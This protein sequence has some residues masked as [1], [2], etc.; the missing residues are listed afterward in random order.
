LIIIQ[1][2]PEENMQQV[3][4]LI[5]DDDPLVCEVLSEIAEMSGYETITAYDGHKALEI[6]KR[7]FPQ[8][9]MLDLN[10]PDINGMEVLRQTKSI[11]PEA[12]VIV[13]TGCASMDLLAE[14]LKFG[15][16]DFIP[17][18]F[19]PLSI[20]SSFDRASSMIP[21]VKKPK[22]FYETDSY[23]I[24][25]EDP[26]MLGILEQMKLIAQSNSNIMIQGESGTG[27]ELI[28]RY[29][30]SSSDRANG[31]FVA[32]N[33]AALPEGVLESELFGHEKGAFTGAISRRIGKI[34]LAH[35]G[36]L[37]LDEISEMPKHFQSK[38]LRAIQEREVVR[39]GGNEQ[40]K[41]DVRFIAT[42]N[43]NIMDEVNDGRFREDLFYR[44]CVI[45][46]FVPP[47]RNRKCD[48]SILAHHFVNKVAKKVGKR[49]P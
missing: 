4:V 41:V 38:L 15:A 39:V 40:V 26:R 6:I 3:S 47:L 17:K 42:T 49:T 8:I 14:A 22:R 37:L 20:R 34:E 30:H 29:I 9:I 36:T 19:S 1:L 12:V 24:V 5:V 18:P 32:V 44:L 46:V 35:G 2:R 16:L 43:R 7:E 33:C 11:M 28:A 31:P 25:T 21:I 45:P 23:N 27:K 10:L 13:I 48:I